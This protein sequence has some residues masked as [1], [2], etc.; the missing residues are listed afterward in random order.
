MS[1]KLIKI[2]II[3]ILIATFTISPTSNIYAAGETLK[4]NSSATTV[5]IGEMYSVTVS[6]NGVDDLA[7]VTGNIDY[8]PSLL[9]YKAATFQDAFP[10]DFSA[11][12]SSVSGVLNFTA[13]SVEPII[14]GGES[15]VITLNFEAINA[16]T[17][18]ITADSI[19][20]YDSN[21][22]PAY[23][24]LGDDIENTSIE[25]ISGSGFGID[26]ENPVINIINP[27]TEAAYDY[28]SDN[29]VVTVNGTAS[30]NVGVI[31]VRWSN[32][33]GATKIASGTNSW[34]F[35]VDLVNG[36]NIIVVTAYD[37][38]GN[39]STDQITIYHSQPIYFLLTP[40]SAEVRLDNSYYI[41]LRMQNVK[42]LLTSSAI[43]NYDSSFLTYDHAEA[44]GS[45]YNLGSSVTVSSSTNNILSIIAN[46]AD[47]INGNDDVVRLYFLPKK[48][49]STN[50]SISSAT[51]TDSNG[52]VTSVINFNNVD[53]SIAAR[54]TT[55]VSFAPTQTTVS[56]GADFSLPVKI[57]YA[58]DLKSI[59][60]FLD[61]DSSMVE[62]KSINFEQPT[63]IISDSCSPSIMAS[64]TSTEGYIYIDR[65]HCGGVDINATSTLFN[66]NLNAKNVLGTTA[67]SFVDDDNR[68][69]LNNDGATTTAIWGSAV[70]VSVVNDTVPP[71]VT[72]NGNSIVYLSVED[73]YTELGA[74]AIDNVDGVL[75]VTTFGVAN[76]GVLGTS[77]I[78]Y[79]ATDTAGNTGNTTR[80]IIVRDLIAP[81]INLNGSSTIYVEY[82]SDYTELKATSIDNYD[83]D[84]SDGILITGTVATSTLGTS[85]IVYTSNDSSGNTAT[86]SREVVVRDTTKPVI[87]LVGAATIN[88]TVGNTY[89]ELGASSTDLYEGDLSGSIIATGTVDTAIAGTYTITYTVS[90]S[91]GNAA[92]VITRT[93]IVTAAAS[94]GSSGGSSGGS[95]G[96]G[97]G[98]GGSSSSSNASTKTTT[99]ATTT[100]ATT[101]T[102]T[103]TVIVKGVEY[104]ATQYKNLAG[105]DSKI[106]EEVSGEE[107]NV[108][109]NY[110]SFVNLD[111]ATLALYEKIIK[112]SKTELNQNTKYAI[113]YFIYNGTQT[114]KILGAGE[115]AGVLNSYFSVYGKLPVTAAEW[116]DVIKIG[117]GRWPAQKNTQAEDSAAN[118][119]FNKIYQRK[120]NLKNANDNAAVSVITY[121]L[122]PANRNTNSE[123]AAIKIFKGIYGRNPL[124]AIDWDITR[125]IAYS[126]A[127]R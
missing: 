16:G 45:F 25:I 33:D 51:A 80:T 59:K 65:Y 32:N 6:I 96:G 120:A 68:E 107:A 23:E 66:I 36:N 10:E 115:R 110:G 124:S 53:V 41:D 112:Q 77:T 72:L 14:G 60:F 91:S 90:D 56:P 38:T 85:T 75:S 9:E 99:A 113:A 34:A 98:G 49:G 71:V 2:I 103:E 30:D 11:V 37:A 76:T 73:S 44:I 63:Y 18:N 81:V 46:S 69:I 87:T 78:E 55:I 114:T 15:N 95:G 83:G 118:K 58:S 100:V 1:K 79:Y 122:R 92:D 111:K 20:W 48:I 35:N 102:T 8:D 13:L 50:V 12:D 126:G 64:A 108:V 19:N 86:T 57:N 27:S 121:G 97:G 17:V 67:I 82:G 93:V 26:S 52:N 125:A 127:K 70:E 7:G 61:F 88:L 104:V 54:E 47:L 22:D 42:N 101:A 3:I 24:I 74:T 4:L 89:T 40:S 117:N 84:I 123:K 31:A 62:L 105:L 39:S 109:F 119:Y 106:V 29:S 94:S 21:Y 43:I 116:K 5:H 28:I